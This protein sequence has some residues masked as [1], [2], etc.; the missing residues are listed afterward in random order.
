MI[1]SFSRVGFYLFR[2]EVTLK[3]LN[4]LCQLITYGGSNKLKDIPLEFKNNELKAKV[5]PNETLPGF[6]TKI[7]M[8]IIKSQHYHHFENMVS[9][10][11]SLNIKPDFNNIYY[12]FLAKKEL[13]QDDTLSFLPFED[14]ILPDDTNAQECQDI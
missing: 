12:T 9:F 3:K 7:R 5:N 13:T 8:T 2:E 6:N 14:F 10:E 4:Q 1:D 11:N